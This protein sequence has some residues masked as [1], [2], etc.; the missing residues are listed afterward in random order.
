MIVY[1]AYVSH[2]SP[3]I[4]LHDDDPW[5]ATFRRIGESVRELDLETLVM[6]SPHFFSS[7]SDGFLIPTQET[8]VNVKDYYGF[9]EELYRF[10]YQ[11][12]NDL[13]L[14]NGLLELAS[15]HSVKLKPITG[16]GLDHGSWVPLKFMDVMDRKFVTVSVNDS[17]PESHMKLG[18]LIRDATGDRRVGIIA[19]GSPTHRLDLLYFGVKRGV[20]EFDKL[21]MNIIE[22]GDLLRADELEGTR[23]FKYS[24]PEGMNRPFYVLA[25]AIGNTKGRVIDYRVDIP[26]LSMLATE[27]RP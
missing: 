12:K 24:A 7:S 18:G 9:P 23:E 14:V 13:E 26:G 3:E 15:S 21:L 8:L 22:E 4:L 17:S 20:Y 2:G 10:N 27:F 6:I 11:F 19:T 1:G 16:W 5:I 25:G